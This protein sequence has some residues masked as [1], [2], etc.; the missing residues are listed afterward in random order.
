MP[1]ETEITQDFWK[2][3][4]SDMTVM[5]GLTGSDMKTR[6]MTAQLHDDDADDDGMHRG[7]IWFFTSRDATIVQGLTGSVAAVF[8]FVSKG[9]GVFA[10]V[11]GRLSQDH[12]R[13]VIDDL[14]NPFVAAWYPGGKDDPTLTLL[15]FDPDHAEIWLDGSSLLAG[16]KVLVG[17]NPQADYA[18]KVA[19]VAL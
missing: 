6:P 10:H 2:A 8:T 18:G 7:P 11:T 4:R 15:R 13:A 5:L 3:L 16:L 9:N 17:G 1:T 14:W 19:R 12:D